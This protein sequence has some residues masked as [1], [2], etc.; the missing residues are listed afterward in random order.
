MIKPEYFPSKVILKW[1]IPY[2][3]TMRNIIFALFAHYCAM[4]GVGDKLRLLPEK[5]ILGVIGVKKVDFFESLL[6]IS[7]SF[8][9]L[10]HPNVS[11]KY[12][13]SQ[14]SELPPSLSLNNGNVS[15]MVLFE[16]RFIP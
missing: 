14:I 15:T 3:A 11:T 10:H 9:H 16:K 13:S 4:S 5:D 7:Y 8:V 2:R 1:N 12:A 6:F